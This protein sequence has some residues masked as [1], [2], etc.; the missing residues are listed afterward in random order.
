MER[1]RHHHLAGLV[2]KLTRDPPAFGLLRAYR[3][4][5]SFG[6]G[7]FAFARDLKRGRVPRPAR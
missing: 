1:D 6:G 3:P 4:A 2:V 5:E 7:T